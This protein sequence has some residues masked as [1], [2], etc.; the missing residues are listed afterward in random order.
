MKLPMIQILGWLAV[1]SGAG[2]LFWY[3]TL[4]EWDKAR[5]D[6]LASE[7]AWQLYLKSLDELTRFEMH[8]VQRLTRAHFS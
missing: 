6:D 2:A 7:Y 4:D 1:V 3:E 5:A 8:D